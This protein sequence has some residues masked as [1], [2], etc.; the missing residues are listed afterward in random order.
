MSA[1]L[2]IPKIQRM[3]RRPYKEILVFCIKRTKIVPKYLFLHSAIKESEKKNIFCE[4]YTKE[5]LLEII[6]IRNR[7]AF[8]FDSFNDEI[9]ITFK[10][11]FSKEYNKTLELADK[12]INGHFDLLGR[13]IIFENWHKVGDEVWPLLPSYKIGYYG[14]KVINDIKIV[15][16]LNR[17][18]F[19]PIIGKAYFLTKDEE[20]AKKTLEYISSWVEQ[21]PYLYGVNWME[22]IEAAIRMYSWIFAYNFILSSPNLTPDA[23]FRVLKSIYQHG[24]FIYEFLSDK[25]SINNNHILAEL[26]ALILISLTFPQ[27]RDSKKWLKF[28]VNKLEKEI[29]RQIFEE[30]VIWEH[31]T[32][33]QKFDTELILYPIILLQKNGYLVPKSIIEKAEKMIEFLN[34]ISMKRGKIPLVG[35]EDQGF[36]LKLGDWEYDNALEVSSVG[37][38]LF[39]RKDFMKNKSEMVFW[40]FNG[41]V[42]EETQDSFGYPTFKIFDKSGYGLFKSKN[43]YLLFV[44]SSQDKRY[45]HAAHRHLDMLSF[46]YSKNGEYFIVDPGTY[47]YFGN[48]EMRNRFR[49][50]SMHNTLRIDGR[51]PSDLSGLFEIYPRPKTKIVKWGKFDDEHIKYV[52]A[53]HDGYK[54]LIHNRIIAGIPRG[55][56]LYD[57]V[58]GDGKKHKFESH[59]HLHPDTDIERISDKELML[60]INNEKIWLISDKK[61]KLENSEYSPKYGVLL[62]SKSLKIEGITNHWNNYTYILKNRNDFTELQSLSKNLLKKIIND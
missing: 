29:D 51:E 37:S 20:Y 58:E 17:M 59:F 30:G 8:Y 13:K 3:V 9:A 36:V 40:L 24:K 4:G 19:L 27:F 41:R 31:S 26:S 1:D 11:K 25:W 2:W 52:W 60:M 16:E 32:G 43:D 47:T 28:S 18:Q 35:D 62:N 7:R 38:V 33:Y 39:K 5:E 22:G 46:V 34:L 15:W 44:T 57:F 12:L 56:I 61:I 6:R 54:P 53:T 55:Y 49:S 10:K 14:K 45:L 48:Y 50:I 42:I 21:N 23:N